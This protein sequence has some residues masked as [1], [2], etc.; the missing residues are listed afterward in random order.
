MRL[1]FQVKAMDQG[2]AGSLNLDSNDPTLIRNRR[3]SKQPFIIRNR[4]VL[5]YGLLESVLTIYEDFRLLN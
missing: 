1:L 3:K 4:T 2:L 5:A